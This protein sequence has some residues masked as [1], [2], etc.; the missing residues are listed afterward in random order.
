MW[1]KGV[2]SF[3]LRCSLEKF[4]ALLSLEKML[5]CLE[6]VK[7]QPFLIQDVFIVRTRRFFFLQINISK[8]VKPQLLTKEI[9]SGI[10]YQH[11]CFYSYSGRFPTTQN[12]SLG[13]CWPWHLNF[14]PSFLPMSPPNAATEAPYI[15]LQQQCME[16]FQDPVIGFVGLLKDK[17]VTC[18]HL[19]WHSRKCQP[20]RVFSKLELFTVS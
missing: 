11:C 17:R 20:E 10:V 12:S 1:D 2:C 18:N 9:Q 14:P 15:A 3:Q 19:L 16:M 5:Y 7:C 4:I 13:N 6:N 8:A